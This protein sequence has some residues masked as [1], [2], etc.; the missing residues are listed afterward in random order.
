[1]RGNTSVDAR[2]KVFFV[3]RNALI[4]HPHRAVAAATALLRPPIHLSL[5]ISDA[6]L[7]RAI[8]ID[9]RDKRTTFCPPSSKATI[10]VR[11][12]NLIPPSSLPFVQFPYKISYFFTN[13]FQGEPKNLLL[14]VVAVIFKYSSNSKRKLNGARSF[15][16]KKKRK[17]KR[18]RERKTIN[19]REGRERVRGETSYRLR[20]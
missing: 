4:E 5:T 15:L 7:R 8:T 11:E 19:T 20:L 6:I 16:K 1:M 2:I 10:N 9:T 12:R 3:P 14:L 17:R 13:L 18:E